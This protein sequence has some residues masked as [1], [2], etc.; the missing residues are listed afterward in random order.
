MPRVMQGRIGLALWGSLIPGL[1]AVAIISWVQLGQLGEDTRDR[2]YL[3]DARALGYLV[4]P[5]DGSF[6]TTAEESI[7]A[8]LQGYA[9]AT[10][11]YVSLHDVDGMII[12]AS[13]A[14]GTPEREAGAQE[15]LAALGPGGS[16]TARRLNPIYGAE[17]AWFAHAL[18]DRSGVVRI[19]VPL[20]AL[21]D[22]AAP[23]RQLLLY[24]SIAAGVLLLLLLLVTTQRTSAP[25]RRLATVLRDDRSPD[26]EEFATAN[27]E[28][29]DIAL[30]IGRRTQEEQGITSVVERQQ[31]RLVSILDNLSVG[32]I[33][34][35][36]DERVLMANAAAAQLFSF[37]QQVDETTT[38][39]GLARDYEAAEI[40][41]RALREEATA[42]GEI[43]HGGESS[44]TT[45]LVATPYREGY[46]RR[47]LLAVYDV[48][49]ERRA[50][51]L[52]HA[53]LA[54]ASH[55]IRTPL[56]GIQATLETLEL[57]A[58]DDP[59][60]A[61][62]FV[63]SAL[64][65]VQRLT[66]FVESLLDLSRLEMGWARLALQTIGVGD[67]IERCVGMMS[68]MAARAAIELVVDVRQG[69]PEINADPGRLHQ[70]LVNLVHNAIKFTPAGGRVIV[71]ADGGN[72]SVWLR[73]KDTGVGIP[74]DDISVLMDR[75][76]Q[77]DESGMRGGGLGLAIVRQIVE[78]H[79]GEVRVESAVGKGSVFSLRLPVAGDGG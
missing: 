11:S 46:E 30:L 28:V 73:V 3:D 22:I 15:I 37:T 41:R 13:G 51:R 64:V 44:R 76:G 69:L 34:L 77:G 9:D 48:S 40:A 25:L 16:G 58:I 47:V 4:R 62:P 52:R 49:E 39:L 7:G 66:A 24:S 5:I 78:A 70:A 55:E 12:F 20:S 61:R 65:E 56:A 17:S 79:Q 23:Y 18:P 38:L 19:A 57:G 33:V 29:R 26:P 1:I 31:A 10:G 36:E 59:D 27:P 6:G 53:F 43:T 63:S 60:A 14:S 35:A 42:V 21:S 2:Q 67:T 8:I 68:S 32:V 75:V 71:S 74:S 45:R 54:N 72:G 50:Q